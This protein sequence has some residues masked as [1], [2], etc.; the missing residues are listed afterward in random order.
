[1][2]QKRMKLVACVAA[3]EVDLGVEVGPVVGKQE[4]LQRW[5]DGPVALNLPA[6][7]VSLVAAWAFRLLPLW[8][9][10]I[11]LERWL[12]GLPGERV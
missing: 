11:C 12:A 8:R 7:Q 5:V 10:G 2:Q 3:A 4:C 6:K 9:R 1:M